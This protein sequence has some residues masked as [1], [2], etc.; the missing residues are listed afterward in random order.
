MGPASANIRDHTKRLLQACSIREDTEVIRQ[1]SVY[2]IVFF[3]KNNSFNI[4]SLMSRLSKYF[5][6]SPGGNSRLL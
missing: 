4:Y 3:I 2:N 5:S 6:Q 1:G